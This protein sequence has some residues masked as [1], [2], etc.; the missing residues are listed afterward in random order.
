L[1]APA[2]FIPLAEKTGLIMPIGAWVID[3]ACRQLRAWLD[4]GLSD[5]RLAVN[6]SACQLRALDFDVSL[7]ATLAQ[8]GV[9]AKHLE[10]ELTESMLMQDP[11]ATTVLLNRLK[12][13][14]V[15]LSLDDFGTG[16]SS[17]AYLRR[18]PIDIIKIDQSFVR[19][20]VTDP[21]SAGIVSTVI[22]MAQ[23]MHL[24]TIAEGVETEAQLGYLRKL[25]CEVMQGYYFSRPVPEADFTD[26][27]LSGKCLPAQATESQQERAL[28]LV[29]DEANVLAALRRL[30]RNEGYRVLTAASAREGLEILARNTVQVIL[31]DQ[32]MPEM[33]GTEF[34]GR[35]KDIHP[36]TV[37]IVL[38]GYA[39]LTTIIDAVNQGAI[40]KFLVKPWDD[41][42][43]RGH[44]RDAFCFHDAVVKPR[45]N[46][47]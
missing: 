38:S 23:R 12:Q 47:L 24:R 19:D 45:S 1:T 41:D 8:H 14:G 40:Y 36:D 33:T 6:V 46:T 16:Y 10:L 29:D 44:I 21:D 37:R 17:L 30:L 18:F 34:F 43:L 22:G 28:L 7:A 32:R 4:Q 13:V 31:S 11:E 27:L 20:I 2:L 42:L 3:T 26:M 39:E 35:V 9:S 25:G 15:K 5:V